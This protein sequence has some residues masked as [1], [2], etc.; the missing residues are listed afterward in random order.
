LHLALLRTF[1]G[2]YRFKGYIIFETFGLDM[3]WHALKATKCGEKMFPKHKKGRIKS[4][5]V[6]S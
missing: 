2:F 3:S 4:K 1:W 5:I 6:S